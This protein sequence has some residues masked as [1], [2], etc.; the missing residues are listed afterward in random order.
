MKDVR[1]TLRGRD[2]L[3]IS[4]PFFEAINEEPFER[5]EAVMGLLG[6]IFHGQP[7]RLGKWLLLFSQVHPARLHQCSELASQ[8]CM[9]S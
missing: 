8:S 7:D 9:S 4:I 2:S 1:V 6:L 5:N 3:D